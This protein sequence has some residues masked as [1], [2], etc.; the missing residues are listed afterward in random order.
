MRIGIDIDGVMTN[1][2]SFIVDYG[3]KFCLENNLT[4][5]INLGNY[6]ENKIL[7]ISKENAEKFWNKY[8]KLYATDCPTREH[9]SEVIKKLKEDGHQIYLVTARNEWGLV[10]ED[11]G[12][13]RDFVNQWL[14]DNDIPYDKIVYTENSKVPYIVGNYIDI[15]IE[16]K[17]E[18]IKEISEK[19]PVLCFNNSYNADIQGKDITRIYS[20]YDIYNKI[21]NMN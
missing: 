16:D 14:K 7:G 4:Y 15:M 13:M 12:K 10:G 1:S 5:H 3:I 17:G 18:N 20:W 9:V 21:K 2:E 8:L 6:D 11:N 19:I